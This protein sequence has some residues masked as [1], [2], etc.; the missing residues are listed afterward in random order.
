LLPGVIAGSIIRV[1][2][3]PGPR[4]FELVVAAVLI[5]LGIWLALARPSRLDEPGR[6]PRLIPVPVLVVLAAVVGCVG[7]IYGWGAARS[8]RPS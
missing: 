2:L 5:P 4:V 6:P 8:W 1:E 3:L 7:G